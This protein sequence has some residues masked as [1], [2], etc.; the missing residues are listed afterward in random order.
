LSSMSIMLPRGRRIVSF[1]DND[2]FYT[3]L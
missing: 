2:N 1:K 3:L